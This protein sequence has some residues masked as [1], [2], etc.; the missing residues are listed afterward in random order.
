MKGKQTPTPAYLK[1]LW[2]ALRSY[3]AAAF[4][5][6]GIE[7]DMQKT[8]NDLLQLEPLRRPKAKRLKAAYAHVIRILKEVE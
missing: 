7:R 3:H 1:K 4:D 8:R 5:L 6:E 2:V